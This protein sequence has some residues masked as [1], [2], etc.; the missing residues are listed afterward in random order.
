ME[1]REAL[2][3]AL[4]DYDGAVIIISHDR[5]LIEATA[6]RLWVVGDGTVKPYEDDLS[7]YR[8]AI[9]ARCRW[10]QAAR[11]QEGRPSPR[12]AR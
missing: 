3:E 7:A 1:S 8:Q 10:R 9:L 2:V 6:D 12:K 5:H 4:S 11:R